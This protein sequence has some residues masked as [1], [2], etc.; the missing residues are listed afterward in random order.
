MVNGWDQIYVERHGK[1]MLTEKQF[2]SN[3][4]VLAVIRRIVAPIGRRVDES[5][6]MV[7]ARLTDGS[8]VNAI[9]PPLCLTGP[10]ITIRKFARTPYT[11]RGPDPLRLD[12]AARWP[13]SSSCASTTGA[14]SSSPA[15]PA[16]ARR[17]L[18][19]IALAASSRTT[20]ASSRSR[21]P[22][23]CACSRT[24]SSRWRAGRR[25]SRGRASHHP[26]SGHQRPA[27]AARPHRRRRVPRRRGARHAAGHEHRPRRLADDAPRQ[28]P[29]ATRCAA[30]RRWCSWPASTCRRAPSAS[31]SASAINL[32]V[33][34]SR[35]PDGTRKVVSIC[36]VIGSDES[37][38]QLPGDLH[39]QADRGGPRERQGHR[40][41]GA[42]RYHPRDPRASALRGRGG[43]RVVVHCAARRG[44]MIRA[45]LRDSC[46][47]SGKPVTGASPKGFGRGAR[48][49]PA[50]GCRDFRPKCS[51]IRELHRRDATRLP[52]AVTRISGRRRTAG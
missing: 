47:E 40:R 3:D 35:L 8:R 16:R 46:K 14:T 26:R 20:S 48:P 19:N 51:H 33:H 31:R 17:P 21:T 37:G 24:T 27:H 42:H 13:T 36:E 44:L 32:I 6:P 30:W 34:Q 28:H 22:P 49:G 38:V 5:S 2:T 4:Q 45:L 23:N 18:L 43:G 25:T 1:L 50:G 52:R 12:H 10:T 7:D 9:I 11:H 39:L 41:T 15:A 29:R